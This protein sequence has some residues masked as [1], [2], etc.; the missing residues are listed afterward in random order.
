M[1]D[2]SAFAIP[3]ARGLG[4]M[5]ASLRV[6]VALQCWGAAGLRLLA[7]GR[8]PLSTM[9]SVAKGMEPDRFVLVDQVIGGV[10][11]AAGLLCLTRPMWPVMIPLTVLFVG[12]A[13]AGIGYDQSWLSWPR[14]IAA[15]ATAAAPVALMLIDWFPPRARF[16]LARFL[17]S[18]AIVRAAVALTFAALGL[19]AI[20]E[21]RF[22]GPIADVIAKT[23]QQLAGVSLS[24]N[25]VG[26]V[27]ALVGAMH[28]AFAM[29]IAA[30]RSRGMSAALAAWGLVWAAAPIFA[31]GARGVL[32]LLHDFARIGL[33]IV[34][35]L[36][37]IRAIEERGEVLRAAS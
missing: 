5:T 20:H 28:L 15:S 11:L 7:P 16:S 33:P 4:G 31:F 36:Y 2:T 37:W 29:N 19:L 23:P 13:V 10:L 8:S 25:A 35:L 9:W 22:P 24:E 3:V 26:W 18:V 6:T 12:D 1:P 34:L 30:T 17:I 21:S 32:D 27:L 14:A